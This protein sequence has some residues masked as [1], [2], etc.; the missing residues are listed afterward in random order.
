MTTMRSAMASA[1]SWSCVTMM[2]VTPRRRCS[3]LDLVAQAHAHARI[4]RRERLVE[5]EQRGRGGERAGER[6]ALLL[7]ARKLHRIL[8]ALLGQADEGEQLGDARIDV[9]AGLPSG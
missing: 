9:G 6:H 7:A 5:Q 1:S 3:V 8:G 4:E 2:V